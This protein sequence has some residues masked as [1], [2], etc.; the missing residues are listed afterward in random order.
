[1][2]FP[3]MLCTTRCTTFCAISAA[4]AI[5]AAPWRWLAAA[6][7]TAR[8]LASWLLACFVIM[9]IASV[10]HVSN[11]YRHLPHI[12]GLGP[13]AFIPT[14]TPTPMP[15]PPDRGAEFGRPKTADTSCCWWCCC[16]GWYPLALLPTPTPTPTP[17]PWA[18]YIMWSASASWVGNCDGQSEQA[19]ITADT[20]RVSDPEEPQPEPELLCVLRFN[21]DEVP[22]GGGTGGAPSGDSTCDDV[23]IIGVV[24][25]GIVGSIG[26]D[27]IISCCCWCVKSNWPPEVVF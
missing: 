13:D 4:D 12:H 5:M 1:M 27:C 3:D 14:S 8:L 18:W 24:V 11:E 16:C 25:V 9:C 2:T 10:S 17:P 22:S 7:S 21:G 20:D 19:L 6:C 15:A 26:S 23:I